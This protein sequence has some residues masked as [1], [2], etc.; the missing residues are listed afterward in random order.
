[1]SML[2]AAA[3]YICTED[4]F[5][6]RRLVQMVNLLKRRSG[7][8]AVKQIKFLDHIFIEHAAEVV[9]Q[10]STIDFIR[11]LLFVSRNFIGEAGYVF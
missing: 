11:L 9:R 8:S 1:M 3:A 7:E 10:L 6:N 5:P 2:F 4:V